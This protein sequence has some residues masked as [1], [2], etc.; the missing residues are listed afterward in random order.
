MID[1]TEW[2][3]QY[4]QRAKS[5]RKSALSNIDLNELEANINKAV[6]SVNHFSNASSAFKSI[7]ESSRK[8][9]L[10]IQKAHSLFHPTPTKRKESQLSPNEMTPPK[11]SPVPQK[12]NRNSFTFRMGDV[13]KRRKAEN[14]EMEDET[15]IIKVLR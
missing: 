8:K 14:V 12:N 15:G 9:S 10:R 5:S 2:K 7:K 1:H 13:R 11:E 4:S 6:Q 3:A